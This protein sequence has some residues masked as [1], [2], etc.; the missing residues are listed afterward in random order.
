MRL[1]IIPKPALQPPSQA[2]IPNQQLLQEN[3]IA[4]FIV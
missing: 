1:R 3:A 2:I 4:L